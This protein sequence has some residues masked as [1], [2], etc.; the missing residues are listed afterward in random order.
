MGCPLLLVP[1]TSIPRGGGAQEASRK[2]PDG[3]PVGGGE[4]EA[5]R[6]E[7][8]DAKTRRG[9]MSV[10]APPSSLLWHWHLPFHSP[11]HP[12]SHSHSRAL[13]LP[14]LPLLLLLLL[15]SLLLTPAQAQ[16]R[17][18]TPEIRK[19]GKKF[20]SGSSSFQMAS[21]CQGAP[22][23]GQQAVTVTLIATIIV[24]VTVTALET[25]ALSE[26]VLCGHPRV[27][28]PRGLFACP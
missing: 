9:H 7:G 6:K 5:S 18:L 11:S 16:L 15:L 19:A 20:G 27:E 4:Q 3:S 10:Q 2:E 1:E 28:F 8:S 13:S 12:H 23:M 17:P 14:L 22:R 25:V 26:T 21:R 24:T